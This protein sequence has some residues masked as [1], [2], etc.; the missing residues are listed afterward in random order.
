MLRGIMRPGFD[1]GL[2]RES[3]TVESLSGISGPASTVWE[4][5]KTA[6]RR[7]GNRKD[8]MMIKLFADMQQMQCLIMVLRI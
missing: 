5:P 1:V 2:K 4:S 7:F 8:L 6:T 3:G